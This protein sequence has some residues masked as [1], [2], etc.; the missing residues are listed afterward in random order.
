MRT[1]QGGVKQSFQ[2]EDQKHEEKLHDKVAKKDLE[3]GK[4]HEHETAM[5]KMWKYS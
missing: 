4:Y 1:W 2:G 5:Q 3:K